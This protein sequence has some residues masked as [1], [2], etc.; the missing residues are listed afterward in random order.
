M[1]TGKSDIY[2][3][4]ER[5]GKILDKKQSGT[6]TE[7]RCKA[8]YQNDQ[9]CY[10]I[11]DLTKNEVTDFF[12]WDKV[13][14]YQL[15]SFNL[16]FFDDKDHPDDILQLRRVLSSTFKQLLTTK[17]SNGVNV[18]NMTYRFKHCDG[19]F[20]KVLCSVS[21]Y[22]AN[23]SGQTV[24][25]IARYADISFMDFSEAMEWDVNE[26]LFDRKAIIESVHGKELY[27]F[28]DRELEIIS[29]L[30]EGYSNKDVAEK[31]SISEHTIATHR[32][33][34]FSKSGCSDLKCLRN[35]CLTRGISKLLVPVN[36]HSWS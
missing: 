1:E 35:F 36:G 12:G 11:F 2:S 4:F 30:F 22:E 10:M 19:N 21:V 8:H 5:I 27:L 13:F 32:K 17:V 20:V 28:T 25:L 14:G 24:Q 34:I 23:D 29:Y 3:F 33:N 15:D 16:S 26:S 31:L 9:D 7:E 18:L 6:D